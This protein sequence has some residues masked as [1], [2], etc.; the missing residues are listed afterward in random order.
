MDEEFLCNGERG[1]AICIYV[2]VF[3]VL[4]FVYIFVFFVL[5]FVYVFVFFVLV[6]VYVFVY[7]SIS[8]SFLSLNLM[9]WFV[10]LRRTVAKNEKPKWQME[11]K[12]KERNRDREGRS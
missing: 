2:F 5:V 7:V 1:F 3:F 8:L 4:V 9:F 6:F 12:G 10:T 11:G